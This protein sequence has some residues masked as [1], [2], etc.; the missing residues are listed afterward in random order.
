M[1][2]FVVSS[3]VWVLYAAE[4]FTGLRLY[5]NLKAKSINTYSIFC[6]LQEGVIQTILMLMPTLHFPKDTSLP[7]FIG[8]LTLT[9]LVE[10]VIST[11]LILRATSGNSIVSNRSVSNVFFFFFFLVITLRS[12]NN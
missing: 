2:L 9:T 8:K 3:L 5:I 7:L 11:V 6:C 12:V 10:T 1:F 4:T